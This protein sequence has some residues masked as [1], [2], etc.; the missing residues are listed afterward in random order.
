MTYVFPIERDGVQTFLPHRDPM[1]FIDRILVA[2]ETSISAET[3]VDTDWDIFKGHFPDLPIM[4]GVL[5][6]EAAAQAGALI[7]C[8]QGGL[9]SDHFIAFTGVEE[10]K[11]RRSVK[12]GEVMHIH[13]E[14]LRHRRGYY[15]FQGHID[16]NGARAVDVKFAATQMPM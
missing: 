9:K 15:K 4:P 6:I 5:M 11:F 13:A 3:L 14:I 2:D 8:L 16:V 12:P 1:L 7:V 10:A